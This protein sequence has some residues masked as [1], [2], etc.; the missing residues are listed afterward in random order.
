MMGLLLEACPTFFPQWQAF[1]DEWKE[2]AD[3][4]PLY[5]ALG[6]LARHMVGMLEQGKSESFGVIFR[7]VERLH[8]EGDEY[9]QT[10]ATVGLLENLQNKGL[11]ISD[12][13]PKQF[14]QYL[15]S[16]SEKWWDKLY[17]F[18]EHGERRTDDE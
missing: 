8:T 17:Q 1:L 7:I 3:D 11:H 2:E 13:D 16:V 6:E 9:V 10:A 18:W 4:L 14:R 12:T 5:L 15:G